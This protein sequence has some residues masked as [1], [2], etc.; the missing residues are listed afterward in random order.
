ME[1]PRALPGGLHIGIDIDY[2]D[3]TSG[4]S[5]LK[6]VEEISSMLSDLIK[7]RKAFLQKT[8]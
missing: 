4:N 5:W 3:K 2:I 7:T 8:N 1:V 6:E